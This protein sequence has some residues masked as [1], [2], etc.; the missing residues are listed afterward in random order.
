MLKRWFTLLLIAMLPILGMAQNGTVYPIDLSVMMTPPY[1]T[2]LKEYVGS[3]RIV[4]QAL[5]K[6]L[7]KTS[8]QFVIQLKVNDNRNRVVFQTWF[9]GYKFN[10][11][12]TFTYPMGPNS[13]ASNKN[14]LDDMFKNA[15]VKLR[16]ECFDEGAYTFTF[17]AFDEASYPAR[18]IALSMPFS[19]PV[20]LQGNT[21]QPLQIYPYDNDVICNHA[22][23][24]VV[25][26]E[27]NVK[28]FATQINGIAYQWQSAN[29]TGMR[30]GYH[31]QVVDLGDI[32]NRNQGQIE[33]AAQSAFHNGSF[34]P[35]NEIVY[36]P[37]YNHNITEGGYNENHAYAWRVRTVTGEELEKVPSYTKDNMP[38]ITDK[39]SPVRVFYF[40]GAPGIEKDTFK[41][42][43]D[44]RKFNKD[45]DKVE[46]DTV[47]TSGQVANA[48]WKDSDVKEKYCGVNV[49]IRKQGQEKWTPFFVEKSDEK[50]SEGKAVDNSHNF[51]NLSYNTRYE[52]RAQYVD[53]SG[54]S[55]QTRPE[56]CQYAPYSDVL[57]FMIPSPIDTAVCGDDLPKLSVCDEG[58]SVPKI[59]SGDTI[60]ANGAKVVVDE[61]SYPNASDSS[62]ISGKGH[63]SMPIVKNIQLKMEFSEI[64]INCAKELV[65]GKIKSIWD[66]QTCAMINLDELT[67]Q[68]STGGKDNAPS[69]ASTE[70]YSEE[71]AKS[72]PS[73][74][75]LVDEQGNVKFKTKDGKVEDIGKSITL[76]SNEYQSKNY[77]AENS[78]YIEFYSTDKVNN[79]FD[80][81]SAGWYRKMSHYDFFDAP[82]NKVILPWL[83]NNPGKLKNIKAREVKKKE[84]MASFDSVMFVIPSDAGFIQL[85]AE[86]EVVSKG[87]KNDTVYNLNIPGWA[88]V[89][90]STPIFAIAQKSD[91][92]PFFDAGKMMVANYAERTHKLNIVSLV[93]E[94]DNS[95]KTEAEKALNSIYGKLGVT[96][97]VNLSV[98][99]DETIKDLLSDGLSIGA[100]A[101]SRWKS[102]T[103][104]MK[105][106][107]RI[108]AEKNTIDK[109]AAYL[110]VVNQPEE[111]EYKKSVEGDM[112]RSQSVGYIF[113]DN[114]KGG[115]GRLIAHE[116]GHGVYK[117]QHTFD[118][119]GLTEGSTDNL[120][121]YNS[122]DPVFLAQYQW[123][124]MQ[125]SVM[126]V[127][128][129]LQ[130]DEDSFN[131]MTA[132]KIVGRG[133]MRYVVD[134]APEKATVTYNESTGSVEYG[135]DTDIN[136]SDGLEYLGYLAKEAAETGVKGFKQLQ[137]AADALKEIAEKVEECKDNSGEDFV[138]CMCEQLVGGE[139][140]DMFGPV[141]EKLEEAADKEEEVKKILLVVGDMTGTAKEMNDEIN[142]SSFKPSKA[143]EI[144]D[145]KIAG[146][147][148]ALCS[149][150][151]KIFDRPEQQIDDKSPKPQVAISFHSSTTGGKEAT[152]EVLC[153]AF[154]FDP[155]FDPNSDSFI[156]RVV[157]VAN[158]EC[159][160][161]SKLEE[162]NKKLNDNI[163]SS[164][165]EGEEICLRKKGDKQVYRCVPFYS[166]RQVQTGA[167]CPCSEL[168][169]A[170]V[171]NLNIPP[172]IREQRSGVTCYEKMVKETY[173]LLNLPCEVNGKSCFYSLFVESNC[174]AQNSANTNCPD[175]PRPKPL[176][177]DEC[178]ASD[179]RDKYVLNPFGQDVSV[180][181]ATQKRREKEK[182]SFVNEVPKCSGW[183]R[184]NGKFTTASP[185]VCGGPERAENLYVIKDNKAQI[186]QEVAP[187]YENKVFYFWGDD[188]KDENVVKR[189]LV[190]VEGEYKMIP[191][192]EY[193]RNYV[194]AKDD[195]KMIKYYT[196]LS[197][198]A[199]VKSSPLIE[200]GKQTAIDNFKDVYAHM[201]EYTQKGN[202]FKIDDNPNK[203]NYYKIRN[204]Y[205]DDLIPLLEE[206][207]IK[208]SVYVDAIG[209]CST[210]E[211]LRSDY[212]EKY[213]DCMNSKTGLLK[214]DKKNYNLACVHGNYSNPSGYVLVNKYVDIINKMGEDE[215][216]TVYRDSVFNMTCRKRT[217]SVS[218]YLGKLRTYEKITS[219]QSTALSC[220]THVLYLYWEKLSGGV[221]QLKDYS[222]YNRGQF[223]FAKN[224]DVYGAEYYFGGANENLYGIN[225]VYWYLKLA[226]EY[227]ELDNLHSI[228]LNRMQ[229][230]ASRSYPETYNKYDVGG[231]YLNPKILQGEALRINNDDGAKRCS[232]DENVPKTT[233]PNWN[234]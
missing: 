63:L 231:Q 132:I 123:R 127:W 3:D 216:L 107:R 109:K 198:V 22:F 130:D 207:D 93:G 138:K 104:E 192:E 219:D 142:K 41:L 229:K 117:F 65:K 23:E 27:N 55:C 171:V 160:S 125:D 158:S 30:I 215:T 74:T 113:K 167:E 68:G 120:M 154:T 31:L 88:D 179:K 24:Y 218:K 146:V 148:S 177:N 84:T 96:Y 95:Y 195:S 13:S 185:L 191:L 64:K 196:L 19:Y 194:M 173:S 131:W 44:D 144:V 181:K 210:L 159:M 91:S 188:T 202:V 79:A 92:T 163:G 200:K 119:E 98:F 152:I 141:Y 199:F 147:S 139:I 172:D 211:E 106:I 89:T 59:L 221:P 78:H 224:D 20:F 71:K 182:F 134:K 203:F 126:F 69:E 77:L 35:V 149:M 156:K 21:V 26:T 94:L 166:D 82:N 67:G 6:D 234:E 25:D 128:S 76:S 49:E 178:Y 114:V 209:N 18:K 37:F 212:L 206:C 34:C 176:Q 208:E 56:G 137:K 190:K 86:K 103:S 145:S 111:E 90:H 204:A 75:L 140:E 60:I 48:F 32:E 16:N 83:A 150:I 15:S 124:V 220:Y 53:C 186:D 14:I 226:F 162:I 4:I 213:M 66:E 157:L 143:K 115:L 108:Y 205:L 40:C 110:F 28:K 222:Y 101:E 5:L 45:L 99:E 183:K 46:M 54:A 11:G 133:T 73:G 233:I 17:Q 187:K 136:F 232:E 51:E 38:S 170:T 52:V 100:D 70:E 39:N 184:E 87:G 189:V 161:D 165:C 43:I 105:A 180:L 116:I 33:S 175:V 57:E 121:D 9:G 227:D 81:D 50:D 62:V 97:E 201:G 122:S 230:A 12:Q 155:N 1:G 8:E 10:P 129:V 169:D 29:P 61:V 197:Y 47:K 118:Y 85:K 228:F 153:K 102:E 225:E 217:D 164:Q 168:Q 7:S 72:S 135:M 58:A 151:G 193:V 214:V 112:P 80:N 223:V 174:S 2:C 36:T 42:L